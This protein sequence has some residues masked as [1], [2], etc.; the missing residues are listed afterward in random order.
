MKRFA[1]ALFVIASFWIPLGAQPPS[2]EAEATYKDIKK[3]FGIVP[4]FL[5]AYPESGIAAA[6]D[7]LKALQ[8][9][10]RTALPNKVKEMIGLAVSAQIPCRYCVYFHTAAARA[11]GA[12]ENELEEAIAMAAATRHWSTVLNGLAIDEG[13]FK[14]EM[15][16]VFAHLKAPKPDAKPSIAITDAA[17]AHKDIEQTFG[18]VPTFLRQFPDVAIAPAWRLMKSV[19]MNPD[20]VLTGKIKELIGIAVAAQIPCHYC[21]YFHTQAARM[22]GASDVEI[23]EA[24]G[25]AAITR[26]W[27]TVLNGALIDEAAFKREVDQI[28]KEAKRASQKAAR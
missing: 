2:T 27:S 16:K 21:V 26:H 4:S 14:K 20:T 9:D 6:W 18:M 23:R 13:D 12:T 17:S 19:Q 3:T 28:M 22:G 7:E 11:N 25:M 15:T 5:K 10:G 1:L 24:I 8:L